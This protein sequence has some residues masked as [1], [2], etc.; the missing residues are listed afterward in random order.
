MTFKLWFSIGFD[1]FGLGI[2]V[3]IHRNKADN[4]FEIL[5]GPFDFVASAF[6]PLELKFLGKPIKRF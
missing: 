1:I 4:Y 3:E 6:F 2:E 5:L